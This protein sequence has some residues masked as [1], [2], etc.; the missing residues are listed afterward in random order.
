MNCFF[1]L[2]KQRNNNIYRVV[3]SYLYQHSVNDKCTGSHHLFIHCMSQSLTC[4]KNSFK[5]VALRV[6]V[7]VLYVCPCLCETVWL[8]SDHNCQ[9]VFECKDV[10]LFLCELF[11]FIRLADTGVLVRRVYLN[12][13]SSVKQKYLFCF[14]YFVMFLYSIHRE[15]LLDAAIPD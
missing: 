4:S 15:S 3:N 13:K 1:I 8:S 7:C 6:Y 10:N 5:P 9:H 12:K 2:T 11:V 14:V